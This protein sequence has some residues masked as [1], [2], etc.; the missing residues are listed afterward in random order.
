F[1][2]DARVRQALQLSMDYAAVADAWGEGWLYSGPLHVMFPEAYTSE[3]IKARPG[4]NP[5]TKEQDIAEAV[6]RMAAAGYPE[7]EGI[8]FKNTTTQ[9]SGLSLDTA[10]RQKEHWASIFPKMTMD[11]VPVTD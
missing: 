6:K 4:Y 2:G 7:G 9:A 5:E 3:E 8:S 11:I 10:I 1:F